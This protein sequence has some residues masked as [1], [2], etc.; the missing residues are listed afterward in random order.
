MNFGSDREWRNGCLAFVVFVLL[1]GFGIGV[2]VQRACDSG[3]RVQSPV[4][5]AAAGAKR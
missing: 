2:A 1:I 5:R 4:A 3:W